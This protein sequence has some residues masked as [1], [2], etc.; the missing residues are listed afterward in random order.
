M[1]FFE[2]QPQQLPIWLSGA[3]STGHAEGVAFEQSFGR[4]KD[5]ETLLLKDAVKLRWPQTGP[6][7]ALEFMARDRILLKAP[8]ESADDFRIRIATA[9]DLW[10]WGGTKTGISDRFAP[11]GYDATTCHVYNNND[12]VWD[13]NTAWYTR[14]FLLLDNVYWNVDGLWSDPGNYDDGAL[15]DSDMTVPDA[16]YMRKS[17]RAWKSEWAFPVVIGLV[18]GNAPSGDGFWDTIGFYDDG[19]FWDNSA[20]DVM[21]LALGHVWGEEAWF[22]GGPGLWDEPGDVWDDFVPPTGGWN[23]PFCL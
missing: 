13:G 16:D 17:I 20:G 6:D 18:L 23:L 19:G 15:W 5:G 11:Y 9:P 8:L 22:G 21:Y 2:T 1:G 7:D 4:I 12:I 10:L 3:D 14:V